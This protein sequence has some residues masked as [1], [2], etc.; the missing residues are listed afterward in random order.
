MFPFYKALP[1][2]PAVERDYA[3]LVDAEIPVGNLEK[4]ISSGAGRLLEK[5]ELFDV[6]T[7]SQI[8]EGKKSVAFSVTLRSADSTLTDIETDKVAEKIIANLEKSGADMVH[9]DVMDGVFVPNITFGMKMVEDIRKVTSLPLDCHLMISN[10]E[11][12]VEEFAKAG[13]TYI[14]V[15]AETTNHLDRL[16]HQI[17]E[18]GCKP[19]VALN[20]ATPL[21]SILHV[22]DIVDMVL[23]MS[24]NPGFGGQKLIPYTLEKIKRLRALCPEKDIQIDLNVSSYIPDEYIENTAQKIEIYQNIALA[25][26]EED[27]INITEDTSFASDGWVNSTDQL[28][29]ISNFNNALYNVISNSLVDIKIHGSMHVLSKNDETRMPVKQR[30][31]Y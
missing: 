16:L 15:H 11:Q 19:A 27:I 14:S 10:P 6:Y 25:K 7:G 5:I 13:A 22:L 17:R 29:E 18:L 12:Y 4:A 1:K 30:H 20:P 28:G 8:P 31:S 26:T 2:F 9:C 21:E 3:M 24:V 23:I